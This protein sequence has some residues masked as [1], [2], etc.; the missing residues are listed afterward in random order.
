MSAN[1]IA[2]LPY[3]SLDEN[4]RTPSPDPYHH[5]LRL[6]N[7]TTNKS[8]QDLRHHIHRVRRLNNSL[9][10]S[11]ITR[12]REVNGLTHTSTELKVEVTVNWIK[13]ATESNFSSN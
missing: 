13:S 7:Q 11:T 8:R 10:H 1:K 9:K 2:E 5:P 4:Y 6:D 12:N 3:H